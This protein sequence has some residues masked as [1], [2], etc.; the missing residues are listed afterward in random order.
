MTLGWERIK[1]VFDTHQ[2]LGGF[3]EKEDDRGITVLVQEPQGEF[4]VPGIWFFPWH[5]ILSIYNVDS[6][7]ELAKREKE[8]AKADGGNTSPK[9]KS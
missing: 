1:V 3:L 9:P 8:K 6:K 2:T 7:K 5:N 4:G